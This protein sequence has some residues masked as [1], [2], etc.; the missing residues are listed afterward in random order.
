M[1]EEHKKVI[2]AHLA[3]NPFYW[4]LQMQMGLWVVGMNIAGQMMRVGR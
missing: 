1:P 4:A 3:S 2:Q